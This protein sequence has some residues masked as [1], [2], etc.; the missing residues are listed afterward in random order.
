MKIYTKHASAAGLNFISLKRFKAVASTR[1]NGLWSDVKRK[2]IHSKAELCL[3]D[4]E[5][6]S[7]KLDKLKFAEL[8][9]FF[10]KKCWNTGEHG[11]I[12]TDRQW[13]KEFRQALIDMGFSAQA[14]KSADYSEQGM[15]GDNYVSL[16]VGL[17]FLK[18]VK[19]K[20]RFNAV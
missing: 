5:L 16:D 10:P 4:E 17:S 1:G 8:R 13:I 11:L 15:Q 2:I 19:S 20:L 9:V 14:A 3:W 7:F 12:Y 6:D 18:Q